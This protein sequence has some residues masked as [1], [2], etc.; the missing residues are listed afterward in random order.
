[1][2]VAKL[3]KN[4]TLAV[5]TSS[6]QKPVMDFTFLQNSRNVSQWQEGV[7]NAGSWKTP[8]ISIDLFLKRERVTKSTKQ[9]PTKYGHFENPAP[10][11]F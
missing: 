2:L 3:L 9:K 4:F 10:P 8:V 1:M 11:F 6:T 5:P 7:S